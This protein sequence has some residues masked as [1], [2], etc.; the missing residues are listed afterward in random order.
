MAFFVSE[1]ILYLIWRA[2]SRK[3]RGDAMPRFDRMILVVLDGVGIG[4]MPDA[5]RWGDAGSDTLGHVIAAENPHLPNLSAMGLP[6]IR[7]LATLKMHGPARACF[8]KAAI[9]SNGKDTTVGHWEMAGILSLVPFPT[10]P[11][12]FPPRILM[13]FEKA[14]GRAAL[15]NRAASGTEIIKELGDEHVRTGRPIVYTSAD[16]VFQIAA[17]EQ[18]VPL[19]ELYRIC[20]VARGLLNGGDRV[21][22]VIARPFVGSSGDYRRTANRKDFAVQ[23]PGESLL[24][25]MKQ[26]GLSVIG[27]GKVASIFD[28]RGITE[29][30]PVHGNEES[31]DA[32]ITALGR[33]QAGLIFSNF[34]DFDTLWGHRND[35]TGFARGLEAFDLRLP[36]LCAA[37]REKD[38][39][40]ITADH[41]CDPKAPGTDHTREYTPLLVFSPGMDGGVDLGTRS[42]LADIGQT[43][44]ENFGIRLREG[45]SFFSELR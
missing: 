6:A 21:A 35:S 43:I 18:V 4:A 16:S 20:T 26:A 29:D 44:A 9:R 32:T 33:T 3:L 40:I 28:G 27:V 5:A 19:E 39:L 22:R 17:H 42:S 13:P 12:G 25:V 15:G 36:E 10:Y 23:P 1:S 11:D 7:P 2:F 41:G 34:G 30:L 38:C 24:D 8:G 31:M 14:I 45:K 37:L